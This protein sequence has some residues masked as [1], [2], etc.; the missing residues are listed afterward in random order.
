[1]AAE[2]VIENSGAT[3]A[4]TIKSNL[5]DA[6]LAARGLRGL[7]KQWLVGQEEMIVS[8]DEQA[9][10]NIA[11]CVLTA[12]QLDGDAA[13]GMEILA[14]S[15]DAKLDAVLSALEPRERAPRN[16]G[17]R[18]AYALSGALGMALNRAVM[19]ERGKG[20]EG[21]EGLLLLRGADRIVALCEQWSVAT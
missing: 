6:Q 2:T 5:N 10:P 16:A 15:I 7:I 11:D 8:Q 20:L 3:A 1:M 14:E 21:E 4:A 12:A 18:E 9:E 13:V 19:A 17:L